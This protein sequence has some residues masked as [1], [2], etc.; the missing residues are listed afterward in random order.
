L[1]DAAIRKTW[2]RT[3]RTGLSESPLVLTGVY[4]LVWHVRTTLSNIKGLYQVQILPL[5]PVIPLNFN[6]F[7]KAAYSCIFYRHYN[8]H[9]GRLPHVI[10]LTTITLWHFDAGSGRRPPHQLRPMHR[11]KKPGM[12]TGLL[13]N[14]KAER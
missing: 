13:L 12:L 6:V 10:R 5:R 8:R 14:M 7:L 1:G 4:P 9:C 3:A 11:S 2:E